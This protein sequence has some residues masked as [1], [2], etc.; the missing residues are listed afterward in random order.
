MKHVTR[1]RAKELVDRQDVA[2]I[3]VLS[4]DKF[5]EFHLPGAKNI[6][7]DDRFKES[8][9]SAV[10]DQDHL[11][12][13]YCWDEDCPQSEKAA[14]AMEELGYSQVYDYAAGKKDWRDAGYPVELA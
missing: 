5:N 3:E 9:Q 8:I 4:S 13:L 14:K 10:P 1:E 11:V 12:L 6:P 7:F 2:V